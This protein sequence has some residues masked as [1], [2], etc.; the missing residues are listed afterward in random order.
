MAV[1]WYEIVPKRGFWQRLSGGAQGATLVEPLHE[2]LQRLA[3]GMFPAALG[4]VA[5]D[6]SLLAQLSSGQPLA[7][8]WPA[9]AED[10]L[11]PRED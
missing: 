7:L 4:H 8:M 2:Q 3:R 6:A 1:P 5:A 9:L 10:S 11:T